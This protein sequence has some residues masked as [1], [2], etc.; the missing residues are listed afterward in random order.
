MLLYQVKG[1]VNRR[2]RGIR[3]FGV[4]RRGRDRRI[5]PEHIHY[6]DKDRRLLIR[7][8]WT[9]RLCEDRRRVDTGSFV[10]VIKSS[11]APTG[12]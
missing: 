10:P 6:Q 2:V 1:S 7:R 9:Q 5:D 11:S 8:F 4:E 12:V 3:R